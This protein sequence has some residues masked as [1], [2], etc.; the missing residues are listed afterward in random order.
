M[1]GHLPERSSGSSAPSAGRVVVGRVAF[2]PLTEGEVVERVVQAFR[3]GHGGHIVTPNVDICRAARRDKEIAALVASADIAVADGMPL[4]WA[5]KLLGT[6][7]PRRVAGADL[8]WSLSAAAAREGMPIYLLGGPSG[9]PEL[10]AQA[11]AARS[12][13][14][15]VAGASAPPFGFESSAAEWARVRREVVAAGPRLVFVGLGFP[16]QDRLIAGLRADLPDAW[17]IGCGAAVTFA[18]GAARR[19]PEW[20]RHAGLEW[21]HRLIKEPIRLARR[22]LIH[23]LPF[24]ARLLTTCAVRRVFRRRTPDGVTG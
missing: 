16:K 3:T 4:V 11:L 14:L 9:V 12:P 5:S 8:I 10:A 17:F 21:L 15:T 20:M 7:V 13:G 6:P 23:D 18:A 22:Y 2:D 1:S 19:A 24:A